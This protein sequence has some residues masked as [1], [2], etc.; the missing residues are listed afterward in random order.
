MIDAKAEKTIHPLIF[1][2]K[3]KSVDPKLLS[4]ILDELQFYLVK[5]D[6]KKSLEILSKL[7]PEW[8]R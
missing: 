5:M 7:V 1:K 3:E 4:T 6:V 8:G 2:A